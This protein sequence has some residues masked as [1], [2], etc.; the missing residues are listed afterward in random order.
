MNY[1][2]SVTL[3]L[4]EAGSGVVL[5]IDVTTLLSLVSIG[6]DLLEFIMHIIRLFLLHQFAQSENYQLACL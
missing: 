2:S 3:R 5:L 6:M 1:E 4:N